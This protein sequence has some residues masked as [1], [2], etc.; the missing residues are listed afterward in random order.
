[1]QSRELVLDND[2]ANEFFRSC[3]PLES[4]GPHAVFDGYRDFVAR[5]ALMR[6][7][8][9]GT[10]GFHTELNDDLMIGAVTSFG[11]AANNNGGFIKWSRSFLVEFGLATAGPMAILANI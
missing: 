7:F 3:L 2:L 8:L 9:I 5:F 1:M 10:A 6:L 11:R 4:A